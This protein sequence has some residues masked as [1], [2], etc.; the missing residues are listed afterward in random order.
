MS[1]IREKIAAETAEGGSRARAA[2]AAVAGDAM[3]ASGPPQQVDGLQPRVRP[4][5]AEALGAARTRKP[6]GAQEQQLA[7]PEIPGY[8]LYW[9]NDT[10]GRIA[11]AK[12]AGY[13][14]VLD[15]TSGQ[16]VSRNVGR[17]EGSQA[18]LTGYLMK[19]PQ[20]WYQEDSAASQAAL[21]QRL[22]DIREG[23]GQGENQYV[24]AGRH[25]I[26][27]GSGA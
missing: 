25:S 18:G 19:I 1:G 24:V 27:S 4:Q 20:Q 15:P 7:W 22:R 10:P 12:E 23:R 13:E 5:E 16:P 17:G 6:F 2:A 3:A 8:R 11:R 14:H 21:E 26:K 9:F